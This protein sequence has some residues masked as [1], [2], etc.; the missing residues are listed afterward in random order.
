MHCL[1]LITQVTT[2]TP[3]SRSNGRNTSRPNRYLASN[4]NHPQSIG[5]RKHPLLPW[6]AHHGGHNAATARSHAG[7]AFPT[8]TDTP[9]L[10]R[11]VIHVVLMVVNIIGDT[12]PGIGVPRS[13][14]H[15]VRFWSPSVTPWI[16]RYKISFLISTKFRCYFPHSLL[17]FLF[18]NNGELFCFIYL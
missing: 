1:D 13:A 10:I 14:V 5:R 12:L 4:P 15:E 6:T 9:T 8:R 7:E 17:F 18:L 2:R 11:G 3:R 16:W